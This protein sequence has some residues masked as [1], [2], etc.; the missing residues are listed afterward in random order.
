M[1]GPGAARK[2]DKYLDVLPFRRS[3]SKSPVQSVP[4]A[5]NALASSS[6]VV[7]EPAT[8]TAS[9]Q[10]N[11]ATA[12]K[13]ILREDVLAQLDPEHQQILR[14]FFTGSDAL[15]ISASIHKA[16][17]AAE[18]KR[19]LCVEKQWSVTMGGKKIVL[20]DKVNTVVDLISKF[21]DIGSIAVGADPVHAGLPWA[22]ICLILQV[23]VADKEQMDALVNG[24]IVALSSQQTADLYVGCYNDQPAGPHAENLR[25]NLLRLYSTILAFL[26][27]ALRLLAANGRTRFCNALLGDDGLRKFPSSCRGRL[28]DVGS[29][30]RLCDRQLDKRTAELVADMKKNVAG[31]AGQLEDLLAEAIRT[32]TKIDLARLP[33]VTSAQHD[34]Y[35]ATNLSACLQ[36]T[37]VDLLEDITRWVDDHTSE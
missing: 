12:P 17:G 1:S 24:I 27:E 36:G 7:A 23:V 22:G 10:F 21:K 16:I 3:R 29:A 33:V 35:S 11:Q 30:S 2:R 13:L 9:P 19:Q 15:D 20:R 32:R 14:D 6:A 34:S 26:A 4:P 31:I 28:E 18:E 8:S 37:R 5:S 25:E